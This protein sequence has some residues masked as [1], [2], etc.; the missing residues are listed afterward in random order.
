MRRPPAAGASC[1]RRTIQGFAALFLA[2]ALFVMLLESP[3]L[4]STSLPGA[5]S[6]KLHLDGAGDGQ[7]T[8]PARPSKHP[9]RETLSADGGWKRTLWSLGIVSGLELRHLNSTRS[10][11]LRKVA[12]EAAAAGA[13]VFSDLQTLATTVTSSQDSSGDEERGKCPHSIVLSGDE[14]RERGLA[15]EL[16]CGLTLGSYITVAATPHAAH[17]ER[18]PKITLLKEG[19]EPI[20]VSQFMME[21]Q[22]L[23]TV[24][25]EDPPRILHFNPR[26]RGDWSAKP[27]IEQNTCY[28][29]QWGTPLRC[30]GWR[31]RADEETVDGMVKCE[32]WIRD[33]EGRS[34]ESKTSWWL[35][36]LIGRTKTVLVDWPYPFVEDRLF[37]LTLTAGLEGYHV[38]VDGRHVTSFPYRTGFVLEDATGLSL[39]GD[40]DVQ[41]VFVGTLPTTHPSFSPQKHLEML[42]VWQAP[43][44]SD[45]PVEIFIG[46][47]S[48]GNHFAERM[49]ARKT[50]MSAAQ[51]SSNVVARFFV[52]LHGRKEVNVELKKEAEFFGDIVVVPFM[53][54]YDL[55]VLKT[56]AI[57]EYG[58][59]VVSARYIMKCDDDTF[60]RLESVMAEVKKIRN[61]TSLYIGNMNYH[62]KPLR[63]GKWAVTYEEWPEEDYPIYANGPGYVISSDIADSILSDFVN[64]KLRLFKMEDVSMGMWVD[65][66]NN[67]RPVKYVHTVNFCQFGC[68]D[69][70]YTA[71]YQ[72]PRQMLCLWDKLQA[73]KAQCCNMR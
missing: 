13:R 45:E 66:F 40:L 16:P 22:G 65:R 24:D 49:A 19:E 57:C 55:V 56:I 47:L 29:M 51:K 44:L 69:D 31:S 8:A 21:L 63:N 10:G 5:A 50:W 48:A 4:V 33:D 59:R 2:Y 25:G 12:A 62:H 14:F 34:E 15:V 23:N 43:P 26:L 18:D 54:S 68:I 1:R 27:V 61:G 67:T 38:N 35:N 6:R 70:Y 11:S 9:H 53:D 42:P 64:H 39:N 3:L 20:M 41:S 28:R 30:E 7:R 60:V 17:P 36:R 46:I 52:A 32:K 73:G 71:H 58:V 37:V 72:S